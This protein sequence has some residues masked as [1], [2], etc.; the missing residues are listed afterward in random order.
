[1]DPR[2]MSPYLSGLSTDELD[3]HDI[4]FIPPS[5]PPPADLDFGTIDFSSDLFPHTPSYQGSPF[6]LHSELSDEPPTEYNPADFDPS[7]S[8]SLLMINDYQYYDAPTP[9]EHSHSQSPHLPPASLDV[10]QSFENM[11]F[12]SPGWGNAPLP[13]SGGG[14]K[15]PSPPRLLMPEDQTY[16]VPPPTINAPDGDGSGGGPHLRI[17]PAT[18]VSGGNT[19]QTNMGDYGHAQRPNQS[20]TPPPP[21]PSPSLLPPQ[22]QSQAPSQQSYS[23]PPR[24][25]PSPQHFLH[26]TPGRT[27]S[28]SD[29]S[30]VHPTWDPIGLGGM[31]L[32]LSGVPSY[33]NP[34]EEA[35]D[36][37]QFLNGFLSPSDDGNVVS[38]RRSKS[39]IG[40]QPVRGHVRGSRSEDMHGGGLLAP[41]GSEFGHYL[42]VGSGM[43]MN[44]GSG[45]LMTGMGMGGMEHRGRHVRRASSGS[46]S[47]RGASIYDGPSA[48][49]NRGSPYPSPNV[50][51]RGRYTDLQDPSVMASVPTVN[52]GG[53]TFPLVVSKQNVTTG[54]T[55]KAS[56]NRRKQDA[57]FMC[58]VPGC[59]S[60]FTRSFNLKGHIRSH[61][62]EKP[63]VCPWPGCGKGFARQHDCK[64]HEQLHSNYRPFSCEPCGKMFARMDALN[65]HLRSEGGAECARVLE[66][67]GLEG[68][69]GT[70]PPVANSSGGE[71]LKVEADWDGGAGLALAV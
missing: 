3:I 14:G 65:R 57:T 47:E 35:V 63:F 6:S 11:S 30:P 54:R 52:V 48:S 12:H 70:T 51:P 15:P 26:P 59:G 19:A 50:S 56:H 69:T 60:T 24:P 5:P 9:S 71:T 42:S 39:D 55:A 45:S 40:N 10:A 32:G 23:F 58:P 21:Q 46:R 44:M 36:T 33:A 7:P 38:L 20:Y 66:G 25:S 18:P 41:P 4:D 31:G 17:V 1:M 53:Q 62:E 28:K 67:R 22:S 29:S 49:S 16:G 68:G 43:N 8:G 37:S 64:R 61:N 27:R 13:E 2:V 34:Q